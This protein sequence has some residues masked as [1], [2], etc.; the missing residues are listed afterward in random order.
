MIFFGI[1]G[2]CGVDPDAEGEGPD[3]EGRGPPG[4]VVAP[5]VDDRLP[6]GYLATTDG[7]LLALLTPETRTMKNTIDDKNNED[8][9]G[10]NKTKDHTG[11]AL[12]SDQTKS[13]SARS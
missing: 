12:G 11:S 1:A 6:V 13:R 3:V 9:A 8:T 2:V 10:D 4:G 5:L 7:L